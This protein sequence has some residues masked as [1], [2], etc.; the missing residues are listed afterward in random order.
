LSIEKE[1]EV[2]RK[3]QKAVVKNEGM[4]QQM[5]QQQMMQQMGGMGMG[6]TVKAAAIG[7]SS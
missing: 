2:K 7:S 4:Q 1:T 3:K 5:M 6:G